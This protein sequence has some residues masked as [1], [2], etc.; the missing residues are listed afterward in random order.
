LDRIVSSW[1]LIPSSIFEPISGKMNRSIK[2]WLQIG[3]GMIF[4]QILLG[5]ITRLTGSG[6]SITKWDIVT[7]TV[8]PL[9]EA[10]WQQQFELY[11]QSPQYQKINQGMQVSQFKW[12]F[13]WEYLHRLWARSMGFVF[14][15]PFL[16]FWRKGLLAKAFLKK[17]IL[18]LVLAGLVGAFGWIMVASGL[19]DRPWVNAYK[20]SLHLAL[21]LLTLSYL[22]WIYLEYTGEAQISTERTKH[23]AANILLVLV[24]LQ[25]LLGGMMAG[26]KAALMYPSFP[27]MAGHILDPILL[28]PNAWTW[29]AFIDY[30]DS[31]FLTALVQFLHR[32]LAYIILLAF[33]YFSWKERFMISSWR[34]GILLLFQVGL[35]ILTVLASKGS[36]PLFLGVAHQAVGILLLLALV[37]NYYKLQI[38]VV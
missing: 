24:S 33:A 7:G 37:K 2:T 8:P 4:F 31:H 19:V 22:W 6:L 10:D 13:F 17:L 16:Y 20:L 1:H 36:I 38:P 34:L 14:L 21:A 30:D 18:V 3:L 12:I 26:L 32:G 11:K 9:T 23:S 5:G 28:D 29:K 27:L 15:I 35:G 25:I